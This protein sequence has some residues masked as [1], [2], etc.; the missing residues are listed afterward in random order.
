M[1]VIIGI[2]QVDASDKFRLCEQQWV[3]YALGDS[4]KI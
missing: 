4:F 3:V 1:F 2:L